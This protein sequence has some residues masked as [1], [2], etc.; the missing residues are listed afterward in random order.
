MSPLLTALLSW[1]DV[2][3]FQ[4][5]SQLVPLVANSLVAGAVL[6]VV[7]GL[8]SFFVVTRDLPFAVHGISEL[9]FAGASGALLLGA[10]VSVGAFTG[11]LLAALVLAVLGLQARDRSSAIGVL[12]PFGLGLGI[13]FLSLYHGRA[14]NK[15]GLLT[16]QIV[17]ISDTSLG[18]LVGTGVVVLVVLA[19]VWRPLLFASVDPVV[20]SARGVPVR[21]LGVLFLVLLGATVSIAVQVIGALLVLTL[22]VTP[23]AAALRVSASP[24]VVPL[25]AAAFGAFAMVAGI[26]LA[27]GTTVPISPYVTTLSFAVYVG[28]RLVGG[29]RAAHP[30]GQ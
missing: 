23:A 17:A 13:L 11:S 1:R 7:G 28:C 9:S 10:G 16:G 29:R 26:L 30:R 3:N 8:V 14:A 24:V 15:F 27:L 2:V 18:V 22:L 12:M 20:A 21:A 25:L 6:G 5:Y 4:D 19:V